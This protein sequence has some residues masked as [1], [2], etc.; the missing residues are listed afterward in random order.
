MCGSVRIESPEPG[1]WTMAMDPKPM[2]TINKMEK[3]FYVVDPQ[4]VDSTG[5]NAEGT[6]VEA[7]MGYIQ[8]M[9]YIMDP[10]NFIRRW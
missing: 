8:S 2:L 1:S 7:M 10:E 5:K 4:E 6:F 9:L 3:N